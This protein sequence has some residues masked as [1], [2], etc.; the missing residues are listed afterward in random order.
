MPKRQTTRWKFTA[1]MAGKTA[2]RVG[3]VHN[4]GSGVLQ[5][6]IRLRIASA[7]EPKPIDLQ[8]R[9]DEAVL[10]ASGLTK[11]AAQM[12]IGQLPAESP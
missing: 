5:D 6:V 9:L 8:M 10:I 3:Y 7:S 2:I 11:V 12:L 4:K 1:E